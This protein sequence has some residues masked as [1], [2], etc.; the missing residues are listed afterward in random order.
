MGSSHSIESAE[1]LGEARHNYLM[2]A[3]HDPE[4][5]NTE[6]WYY[7]LILP[8][9]YH[10]HKPPIPVDFLNPNLENGLNKFPR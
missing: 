3:I 9:A 4:L 5:R 2:H 6:P 7:G 8:G 1:R 10:T